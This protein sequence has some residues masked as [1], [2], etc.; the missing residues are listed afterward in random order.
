MSAVSILGV[1]DVVTNLSKLPPEIAREL[2]VAADV[3]TKLIVNEAKQNHPY[4]D[5]TGNLTQSIQQ[6]VIVI[7]DDGVDATVEARQPYASYV[8]FGTARSKPYPFMWP[9]VAAHQQTFFRQCK[10]ALKR[11]TGAR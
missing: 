5:R 7:L 3:T 4:M 6:G 1:E 2:A 9:A 10:A 11:A 8:E